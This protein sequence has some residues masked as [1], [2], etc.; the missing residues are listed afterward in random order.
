MSLRGTVVPSSALPQGCVNS[1]D[2]MQTARVHLPY[3]TIATGD[4]LA[5][6]ALGLGEC[7]LGWGPQ[8][9]VGNGTG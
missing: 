3:T 2:E 4:G 6:E 5:G 1:T 7:S 8:Q 9:Y